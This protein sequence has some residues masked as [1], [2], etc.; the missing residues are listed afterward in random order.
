MQAAINAKATIYPI[1]IRYPLANGGIN[2]KMAYAGETTMLECMS[3][4]LKQKQ[5]VIELHFLAS[6]ETKD[7]TRQSLTKATFEAISKQLGF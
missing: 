3:N 2:T 7:L 5:P 6:I 1:A 4:I